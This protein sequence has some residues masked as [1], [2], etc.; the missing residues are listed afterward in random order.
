MLACMEAM[1]FFLYTASIVMIL[2]IVG[3]IIFFVLTISIFQKVLRSI[4]KIGETTSLIQRK[5]QNTY[6]GA[7]DGVM[8]LL[9]FIRRGR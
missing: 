2:F 6:V 4:E 1:D 9:H 7:L 5:V 8:N 3:M